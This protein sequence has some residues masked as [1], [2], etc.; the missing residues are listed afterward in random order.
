MIRPATPDD[1]RAVQA[2]Y[3]PIVRDTTISFELEPPTVDEIRE[4]ITKTL[5]NLPWLVSTD[6]LD[7]IDGYVYAS[8]FRDRAAYQWSVEVTAYVREDARGRGV[9][10]RLYEALFVEL[11][12]LGYFQAVAGIA[13]P[14]E[15]SIAL[16]E[17]VG[18]VHIGTYRHVGYK[19]G[20]WCDVGWWQRPLRP[21]SEPMPPATFLGAAS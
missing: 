8:R 18:F 5:R 14:N 19:F 15:A 11:A 13:L 9:G 7:V 2:I 6:E 17:A 20:A 3:A 1:A 4:R 21:L 16:H 12:R 10:K